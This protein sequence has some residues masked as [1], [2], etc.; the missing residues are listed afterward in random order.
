[1]PI[2]KANGIDICYET[3]GDPN[4]EPLLL[5][6]G[7]TAQLISWPDKLI[8]ALCAQ[9]FY[10]IRHDNRDSGLS[11]KTQGNAPDP[12]ALMARIANGEDVSDDVPYTLS[13]M[14]DDAFGLLDHLG[15][16]TAHVAGAS[17]G[18]MIVQTM[19]IENSSRLRSVT[20]IMSTT[21]DRSVGQASPEAIT[22]LLTPPANGREAVIAQTI[23]TSQT[24]SGPLWD[25]A[26]ATTR[27]TNS[28]DRSFY[29]VGAAF[30]L[31]AIYGTGDRTEALA[32]VD[33]PFLALHGRADDLISWTGATA[34]ADAV[35]NADLVVYAQM[36]H[37]L[38]GPLCP[39]IADAIRGIAQR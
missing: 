18:G 12:A 1:M 27:Q 25:R 7:F 4:D 30:Q 9:G 38:P 20:S 36:G 13:A 10:V 22:A 33:V 34:T 23:E 31:A 17:M 5:V 29:P 8:D 26:E 6:M 24:I 3:H 35:P 11:E 28:Y 37:D 21:G 39:Q 14:S 16:E 15:I 19:A 32:D 2:A